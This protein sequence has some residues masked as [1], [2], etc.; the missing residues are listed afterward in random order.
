MSWPW[1]G[2]PERTCANSPIFDNR[3]FADHFATALRDM[4]QRWCSSSNRHWQYSPAARFRPSCSKAILV[5]PIEFC[6][7]SKLRQHSNTIHTAYDYKRKRILPKSHYSS[8]TLAGSR[9][10]QAGKFSTR[11]RLKAWTILATFGISSAFEDGC[12]EKST[13]RTSWNTSHRMTSCAR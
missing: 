2:E 6:A 9:P 4:W 11:K 5:L 3:R 1:C 7:S 13:P 8:C 10:K 12:C